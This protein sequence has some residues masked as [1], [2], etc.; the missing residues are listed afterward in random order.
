M[1]SILSGILFMPPKASYN[2]KTLPN[3]RRLGAVPCLHIKRAR[4]RGVIMYLHGNATDLGHIGRILYTLSD[5]TQCDVV[6][7]EYPGYGVCPGVPTVSSVVAGAHDALTWIEA[8]YTK[9]PIYLVGR[10]IGT[11]VGM[12]VM[13]QHPHPRVRRV[14]LISPFQSV[15][16]LAYELMG[17]IAWAICPDVYRT[18]DNIT[19]CSCPVTI[20]HGVKDALIPSKHSIDMYVR[21]QLKTTLHLIEGDHNNLNFEHISTLI[22]AQCDP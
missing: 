17:S 8:H 20:I 11:G 5:R 21:H 22:A 4:T 2:S 10:S 12:A 9:V 19:L 14:F 16:Q 7:I 13:A 1:E 6:A 18:I 15:S 3:L